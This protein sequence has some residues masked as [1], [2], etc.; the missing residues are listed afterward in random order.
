MSHVVNLSTSTS[1]YD[2][3]VVGGGVVGSS[4]AYHLKL[5]DPSSSVCVLERDPTYAKAST[6][7]SA[8]SIRQQFSISGNIEMSLSS[9]EFLRQ[10]KELLKISPDDDCAPDIQLVE[11]GY[12]F[13]SATDD[14]AATLKEN[15]ALQSRLGAD[16]ALLNKTQLSERFPWLNT[17]DIILGCYGQSGEGWFDPWALL[18]GL[19]RK[20]ISMGVEY[21]AAECTG[22]E[23]SGNTVKSVR[24]DNGQ[25]LGCGSVVNAAGAWANEIC[26]L[27]GIQECPVRRRKRMIFCVRCPD[28]P[29]E[30]CPL[31]VDPTGI[32]FRREGSGGNFICGTFHVMRGLCICMSLFHTVYDNVVRT[33]TGR[34]E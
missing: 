21:V 14:G 12:L 30:D 6:P 13:L 17:E 31:V 16:V 25:V 11:G 19:R 2:V 5:A 9:I 32:Y 18:T 34:R 8:G 24:A 22:V 15:H 28:G 10:S 7:L 23:V 33:V 29:I 27:A 3:V 26:L 1:A 20:A 4:I